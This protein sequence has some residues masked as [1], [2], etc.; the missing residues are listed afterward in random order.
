MKKR[1]LVKTLAI[2]LCLSFIFST[3]A[4]AKEN[5]Q[6]K[7]ARHSVYAVDPLP[8]EDNFAN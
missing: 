3:V 1:R 6:Y 7:C 4:L 2:S 8:T 5:K